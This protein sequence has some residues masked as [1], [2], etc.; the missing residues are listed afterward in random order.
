VNS[1]T[2]SAWPR[3]HADQVWLFTKVF[4]VEWTSNSAE[5]AVKGPDFRG[6]RLRWQRLE[7]DYHLA[8]VVAAEQVDEGGRG[9][10]QAVDDGLGVEELA[11][12]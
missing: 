6:H 11:V 3:G 9:L 7:A 1:H 8:G 4:D 2:W 12:A 5:R 10:V